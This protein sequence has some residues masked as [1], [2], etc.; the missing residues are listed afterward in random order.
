MNNQKLCH[1]VRCYLKEL[2][3]FRRTQEYYLYR[4]PMTRNSSALTKITILPSMIGRMPSHHEKRSLNN[5]GFASFHVVL[6]SN[7]LG[8][9]LDER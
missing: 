9:L 6:H 3:T 7:Q 8:A 4:C 2:A 5:S 1:E